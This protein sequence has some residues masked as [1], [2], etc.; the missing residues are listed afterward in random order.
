MPKKTPPDEADVPVFDAA[1]PPFL[2]WSTGGDLDQRDPEKE[3]QA[4]ELPADTQQEILRL[5]LGKHISPIEIA[6]LYDIDVELVWIL[7][8]DEVFRGQA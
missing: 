7:I 6:R 3:R 8:D 4:H 2:T 5:S 1:R